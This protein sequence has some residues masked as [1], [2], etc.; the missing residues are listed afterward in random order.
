[1]QKIKQNKTKQK[2]GKLEKSWFSISVTK[3]DANVVVRFVFF[4]F[5]LKIILKG[6]RNYRK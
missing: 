2:K 6:I 4:F 3:N 1:M 5:N